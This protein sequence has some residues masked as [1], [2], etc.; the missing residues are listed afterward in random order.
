MPAHRPVTYCADRVQILVVDDSA[1]VRGRL[2]ALLA[3]DLPGAVV[4]VADDGDSAL[5]LARTRSI[6]V[7]VVDLHMPRWDGFELIAALRALSPPPRVIVLTADATEQHRYACLLRGAEAFLDKATEFERVAALIASDASSDVVR[8]APGT[9]LTRERALDRWAAPSRDRNKRTV[10][11]DTLSNPP[12]DRLV[13]LLFAYSPSATVVIDDDGRVLLANWAACELQGID[14][15]ALFA[16]RTSHAPEVTAFREQLRSTG[17]ALAELRFPSSGASPRRLVLEGRSHG[18]EAVVV[19]R[20]VSEQRH[21]EDELRHLRR[22]ED[23]GYLTASIVHDFNN[24]LTAI[25][26]STAVLERDL[27]GQG[28]RSAVAVDVANEIRDAAERAAALTRRVLSFLRRGASQLQRV[29]LS[30]AVGQMRSLLEMVL[31]P[32]I[33]LTLEL[34]PALGDVL[35]DCEQLDHV[36]VNLVVNARDAMGNGGIVTISTST[37]PVSPVG[38]ADTED[39][40]CPPSPSYVALTV[41]DTGE[42]MPP[43]VREHA[44]ERFFTSKEAGKGTGLGLATAHRFAKQS[45]GCISLHS[46]PG[47]GTTVVVYLPRAVPAALAAPVGSAPSERLAE[48]PGSSRTT[49]A[50]SS[51]SSAGRGSGRQMIAVIEPDDSVRSG[52]RAVLSDRGYTV[53]DAPSG[54][55]ALRQSEHARAPIAL[56]LAEVATPGL[57]ASAVVERLRAAGHPAKL[58]WMSGETDR[59]LAERGRL[60]APLLR[61]AFTP[62]ELARCVHEAIDGEA[63]G[64]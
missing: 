3:S 45:G 62:S 12:P 42:G 26:C 34:D 36:L 55:L 28:G 40:S 2:V 22:F 23:L 18:F 31:G 1:A 38:D 4:H 29:N 14:L 6:D 47:R 57:H 58:L 48:A 20:D 46:A 33:K 24:L 52:L 25:L 56:V 30:V 27:A 16:G 13:R 51:T 21:L 10:Q 59:R 43:E 44:F 64:P 50:R 35:V 9:C 39:P 53:I 11:D 54:E 17:R 32:H 7:V 61:K 5:A 60:H 49:R 15:D 8:Q 63:P 41:R 19:L 37:V